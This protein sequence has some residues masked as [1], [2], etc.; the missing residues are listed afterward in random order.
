MVNV[1]FEDAPM[2]FDL[3][4]KAGTFRMSSFGWPRVLAIAEAYGWEPAGTN[5][6]V[7]LGR[8]NWDGSYGSND[9]QLV[10]ARDAR[11]LAAAIEEALKDDFQRIRKTGNDAKVLPT[12]SERQ[13]ALEKLTVFTS[14]MTIEV[15]AT[16]DNRTPKS[17]RKK[18]ATD[19]AAAAPLEELAAS[20]GL[21]LDDLAGFLSVLSSPAAGSQAS[22][23]WYS[24][25]EGRDLLRKLVAFCQA[26]QFRVQ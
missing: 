6:P 13:Q 9:G 17:R 2:A 11:A 21:S 5:P 20:Q 16:R 7:G 10:T 18:E 1:L 25:Q 24:K 15:E 4:G 12:E 22:D 3:E 26:G 8:S 14:R 23:P 19:R